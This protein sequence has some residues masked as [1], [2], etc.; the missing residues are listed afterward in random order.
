MI[1]ANE[2][3]NLP[4]SMLATINNDRSVGGS[5]AATQKSLIDQM[6]ADGETIV[7]GLQT[8]VI[9]VIK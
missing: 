7:S 5:K 6:L 8:I 9:E 3:P 2:M 1:G 4:P